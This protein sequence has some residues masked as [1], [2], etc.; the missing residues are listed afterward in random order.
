[1]FRVLVAHP[2]QVKRIAQAWVKIDQ[3]DVLRLVHLLAA[4][5]VSE[6]WVPPFKLRE[7]RALMSYRLRPIQMATRARSRLRRLRCYARKLSD[8][9]L[10]SVFLEMFGDPISNPKNWKIAGLG[11][12]TE[13][14][15]HK[16]IPIEASIRKTRQ[17]PYP[18]YGASGIIDHIDDFIFG[19]ETLLIAEDGANL[20]ARVTPIA[21]KVSG[22]YWVNN[23]AHVLRILKGNRIDFIEVCFSLMD[24][25]PYVTGSAQPKLNARQ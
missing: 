12:I 21:F 17:G 5:L 19:E 1:V 8:T 4:D 7:L 18:Y 13:S 15:D 25:A 6:V 10:R 14:L 11:K 16:R 2:S 24:I 20:L 23:H 3:H 9:F 22:K